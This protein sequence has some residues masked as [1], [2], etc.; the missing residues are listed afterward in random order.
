MPIKLS[1]DQMINIWKK[2]WQYITLYLVNLTW[3]IKIKA[4]NQTIKRLKSTFD[5]LSREIDKG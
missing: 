3:N 5:Q 2:P 1:K 4:I